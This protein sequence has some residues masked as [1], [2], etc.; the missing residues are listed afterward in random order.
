MNETIEHLK[1]N[2]IKI[3]SETNGLSLNHTLELL[4][5]QADTTENE[6]SIITD[7]LELVHLFQGDKIK[8]DELL[9]H[10]I[11]EVLFFFF[12]NF[13]LP[14]CEEHIHLTGS[15]HESFIF[16]YLKNILDSDDGDQVLK[17]VS[18]VYEKEVSINS[19]EDVKELIQLKEGEEFSEYLKILY[20]PKVILRNK[21]IHTKA[22]YHMAKRLYEE[23]NVGSIRLKFTLSRSTAIESEKIPG[24]ENVTSEDVVLASMTVLKNTNKKMINFP[25]R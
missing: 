8:I 24:V 11:S 10:P 5:A 23:F 9:N 21:E 20:L 12:K 6:K 17:K 14:Y 15:L 16:P 25:L 1:K 2:L 3:I 4:L 22:S 7:F 18:E 19:E 13:P